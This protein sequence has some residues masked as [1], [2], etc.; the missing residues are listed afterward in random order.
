MRIRI[1]AVVLSAAVMA[2]M[3]AP[4]TA[5]AGPPTGPP[6][7]R[8]GGEWLQP[9]TQAPS[10]RRG[11][12]LHNL[13]FL[14]EALKHAPS[15][16][17][18][19]GVADRIWGIWMNSGGDTTNLLIS[20]VRKALET[21][22]YDLAMQLLDAAIEFKPEYV[23][24]W[25]QRATVHFLK[26]DYTAALA[27]LAQVLTREPRHFGALFGLGVIMQEFGDD[28]RALDVYRKLLAIDPHMKRVPDLVKTLTEKVEGR[29]I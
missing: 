15:E 11:E 16:D 3:P 13:D 14:F 4:A 1:L 7:G 2:L 28:K 19:K 22:D 8:G 21:K 5:Q 24:A 6:S 18:A 10:I 23:E 29:D 12:R 17:A 9:P 26:K 20:R 27:D 25:N